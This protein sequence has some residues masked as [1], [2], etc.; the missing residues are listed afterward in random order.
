MKLRLLILTFF[1]IL[2]LSNCDKDDNCREYR[3]SSVRSTNTPATGEVNTDIPINV[4]FSCIN[5]CGQFDSFEQGRQG[6]ALEIKVIAKYEGCTCTMD[7]PT[8][9]TIY[10]FKTGI[11]GTYFLKFWQKENTYITDTLVIQ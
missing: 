7:V 10:T 4:S 3:Q 11:K 1:S 2:I 6:N 9:Q 8:R 5:G